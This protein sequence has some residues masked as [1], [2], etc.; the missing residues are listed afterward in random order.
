MEN[1]HYQTLWQLFYLNN[2]AIV[3]VGNAPQL[4]S[5]LP[6]GGLVLWEPSV[7]VL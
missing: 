2:R 5:L 6:G 7:G 3:S 4:F 1:F